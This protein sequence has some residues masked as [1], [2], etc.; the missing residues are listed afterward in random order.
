MFLW[1]KK[2]GSCFYGLS[3][4]GEMGLVLFKEVGVNDYCC[5]QIFVG[6]FYL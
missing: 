6:R 1:E 3:G 4:V 5:R 2:H